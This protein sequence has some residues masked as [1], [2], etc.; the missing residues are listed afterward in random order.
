MQSKK[1]VV[2]ILAGSM[3]SLALAGGGLK[4]WAEQG[5]QGEAG[6][7]KVTLNA[8]QIKAATT[9]ALE[10]KPGKVI[11]TEAEVEKGKTLCDVKI[12]AADGKTYEVSV[13]VATNKVVSVE[14]DEADDEDE[15]GDVEEADDAGDAPDKD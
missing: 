8:A 6:E 15:A 5:E 11:E 3:A 12:Q 1:T 7:T 10:S 2:A 13:D 14:E 9:A 4:A